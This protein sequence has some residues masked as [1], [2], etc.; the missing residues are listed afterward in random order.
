[1][2]LLINPNTYRSNFAQIGQNSVFPFGMN[3]RQD[4]VK[5]GLNMDNNMDPNINYMH[6]DSYASYSSHLS[7]S[8]QFNSGMHSPQ[9]QQNSHRSIDNNKESFEQMLRMEELMNE[10]RKLREMLDETKTSCEKTQRRNDSKK[11]IEEVYLYW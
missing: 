9:V 5:K 6:R 3:Q 1:M 8:P 2:S 11:E 7:Q 10:R 4:F